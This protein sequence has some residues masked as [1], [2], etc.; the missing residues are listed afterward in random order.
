MEDESKSYGRLLQM[1]GAAMLRLHLHCSIAILGMARFHIPQNG[2]W[3]G[4]S[5]FCGM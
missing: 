1:T 3:L 4:L 5:P 2:D